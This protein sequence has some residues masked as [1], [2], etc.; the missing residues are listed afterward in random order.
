MKKSG[1][2]TFFSRNAMSWV[3]SLVINVMNVNY[4][5]NYFGYVLESI[6]NDDE[7]D[8]ELD[9]SRSEKKK[10]RP[11]DDYSFNDECE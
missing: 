5:L 10:I 7:G 6:V 3:S 8:D 9:R 4:V 2:G 1:S 11:S